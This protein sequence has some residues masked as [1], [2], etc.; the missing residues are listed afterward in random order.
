MCCIQGSC[1]WEI[2]V[3]DRGVLP[4]LSLGADGEAGAFWPARQLVLEVAALSVPEPSQSGHG[5]GETY[6]PAGEHPLDGIGCRM[7]AS[8]EGFK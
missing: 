2:S 3:R 5:G 7:V 8:G 6:V 1:R 4:T